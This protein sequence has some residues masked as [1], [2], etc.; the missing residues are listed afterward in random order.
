MALAVTYQPLTLLSGVQSDTS[1]YGVGGGES[2]TG[3]GFSP[4]A[5]VFHVS[6]IPQMIHIHSSIW[7]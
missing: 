4:N 7:H 3:T 6:I 5:L 1:T 2:G